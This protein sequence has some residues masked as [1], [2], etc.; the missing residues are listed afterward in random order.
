MLSWFKTKQSPMPSVKQPI[1]SAQAIQDLGESLSLMSPSWLPNPKA[2]QSQK[3]GEQPSRYLGS[4]LE[5][6]DSRLYQPGDEVKRINWRLMAR[7]GKTYTKLFQEERQETWTIVVDQRAAM[8]FGTRKQLKVAQAIK[9]AGYY[10]WQ[11]Q[12]A[13]LLV[14]AVRLAEAAESSPAYEGRSVF[15]SIM[16]FLSVPCPPMSTD[17]VEVRLYDELLEIHQNLQPGARLI[18]ISDFIDLDDKTLSLLATL[19]A[20]LMVKAI[21]IFDPAE[22]HLKASRGLQL[23]GAKQSVADATDISTHQAQAYESWA[24]DYF[25]QKAK[26]IEA[27]G[28]PIFHLGTDEALTDLAAQESAKLDYL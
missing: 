5:Y 21:W 11:A 16:S 23:V 1:L 7:T 3:Q 14:E 22:K 6:E 15:Q 20:E 27:L 13:G 24:S 2:S 8:R 9:V 17:Q 10:A 12:E 26:Q 28:I 19:Q 25:E 4:G 18:L